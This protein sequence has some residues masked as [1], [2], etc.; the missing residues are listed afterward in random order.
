MYFKYRCWKIVSQ[1]QALNT[2]ELSFLL[3]E[4]QRTYDESFSLFVHLDIIVLGRLH[5]RT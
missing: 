2:V 1:T 4:C 5:E 3:H